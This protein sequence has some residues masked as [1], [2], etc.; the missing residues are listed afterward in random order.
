MAS[1]TSRFKLLT[2]WERIDQTQF[3][4]RLIRRMGYLRWEE[5][6][7]LRHQCQMEFFDEE[8]AL[9]EDGGMSQRDLDK[10]RILVVELRIQHLNFMATVMNLYFEE[11]RA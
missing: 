3:H 6:Q 2:S 10:R 7:N 1:L 11:Q 9:L 8:T 5:N 4:R